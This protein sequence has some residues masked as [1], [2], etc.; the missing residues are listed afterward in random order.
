VLSA[1]VIP[2]NERTIGRV[3]NALYRRGAGVLYDD[4]ALVHVAGHASQDDLKRML[5]L[6]QPRYFVPVHG[7]YRHLLGHARLAA[8][9]GLAPERIFLIEDGAGLEVTKT[10]A[11]VVDGFPAGR[12]LVVGKG[13]GDVG[14]VVLRDRQLLAGDGVVAVALTLDA[15]GRIVAGPDIG[16]R[17]VVYGQERRRTR[18]ARGILA[19]AVAGF[20]LVSLAIFDPALPPSEQA[21]SVGPVGWWLGWFLFRIFGYAGFLLPLLLGGWGVAAFVRPKVA[22]GWV[23]LAGLGVLLVAAAGL[24]QLAADTFVAER[25]TRGGIL[26][27]GGWMGWVVTTGLLTTLGRIGAWLLLLAAVP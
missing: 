22:R 20:A 23:P 11:R 17:G 18:E 12:V 5:E 6:T 2:G 21:T 16:S 4:D 27:T 9:T 8:S 25:V 26:A 24:L 15:T 19:L 14:A 10:S 3:I 7:E 1:R 13:V